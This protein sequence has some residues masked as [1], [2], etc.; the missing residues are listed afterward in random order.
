MFKLYNK[1][2]HQKAN[3][4]GWILG[5]QLFLIMMPA[6]FEYL[7]WPWLAALGVIFVMVSSI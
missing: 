7:H 3:S 5:A 6:I 4:F 1:E 2:H